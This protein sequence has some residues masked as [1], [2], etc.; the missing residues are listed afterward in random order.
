MLYSAV[1]MRFRTG[2]PTEAERRSVTPSTQGSERGGGS[3]GDGRLM[4]MGLLFG[5]I[6]F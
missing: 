1:D 5:V 6:M 3:H 2:K 4:S